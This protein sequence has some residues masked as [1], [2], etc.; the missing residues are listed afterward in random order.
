MDT[1]I[2]LINKKIRDLIQEIDQ[3][4]ES[5][6]EE[7]DLKKMK[8]IKVYYKSSLISICSFSDTLIDKGDSNSIIEDANSRRIVL[9]YEPRN[10]NK[11]RIT[12][13]YEPRNVNK[14]RIV[15]DHEPRETS[16][17]RITL[18]HEPADKIFKELDIIES[19]NHDDI[20][21][22]DEDSIHE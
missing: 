8:L 16:K 7:K 18:D 13:D 4:D 14:R 19:M 9:D 11:N 21:I 20:F 2:K 12:L 1:K 6:L 22:A 15:L 10:A 3:L 17:N 5:N